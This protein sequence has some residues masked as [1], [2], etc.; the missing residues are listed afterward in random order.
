M[1]GS[2]D[3]AALSD[4]QEEAVSNQSRLQSFG[5][6]T[7]NT[8]YIGI[9][10]SLCDDPPDFLDETEQALCPPDSLFYQW[11]QTREQLKD[12]GELPVTAHNEALDCVNYFERFD[13]YLNNTSPQEALTRLTAR[14]RSGED[15]V[16]VCFCNDGRQC[17]RHPVA[18][19]IKARLD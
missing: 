4:A 5:Q 6:D 14:A 13:G 17:H 16:L 7:P 8:T 18:E 19:R 9:A 2:I 1:T 10:R 3:T 11:Y 12:N 15:I